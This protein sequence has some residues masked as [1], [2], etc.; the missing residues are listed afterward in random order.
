MNQPTVAFKLQGPSAIL[1]LVVLAGF[2]AG[3][4]WWL[5]ATLDERAA[6]AIRQQLVFELYGQAT[7][8]KDASRIEASI[9]Q[10]EGIDI[11]A[12][13]ARRYKD[14]LVVRAEFT[15][16]GQPL[17]DG[18]GVRY[19]VMTNPLLGDCRVRW[20]A[21]ALTYYLSLW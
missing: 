21:S 6:G 15:V 3:R 9:S 11:T 16:N 8:T 19:F 5:Q 14:G 17:P 13:K 4:F 7:A 1:A 20:P 12:L 2:A 18:K 10:A